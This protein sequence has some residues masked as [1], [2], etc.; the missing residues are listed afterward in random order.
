M[1]IEQSKELAAKY[2]QFKLQVKFETIAG[3][4][5]GGKEFFEDQRLDRLAAE[6]KKSLAK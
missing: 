5:H 6:L 1:P 3:G 2:E 4:K